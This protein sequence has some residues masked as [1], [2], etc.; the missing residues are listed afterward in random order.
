MAM[1][2][3]TLLTW[4]HLPSLQNLNAEQTEDPVTAFT[5]LNNLHHSHSAWSSPRTTS[6][7][8]LKWSSR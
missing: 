5:F 4:S 7:T 2:F 6:S 8:E 3:V 1:V